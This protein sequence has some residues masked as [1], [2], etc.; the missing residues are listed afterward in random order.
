LLTGVQP[1]KADGDV[2]H[3]EQEISLPACVMKFLTAAA[4]TNPTPRARRAILADDDHH[5]DDTSRIQDHAIAVDA[6]QHLRQDREDDRGDGRPG[7]GA[8]SAED[9][10]MMRISNER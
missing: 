10:V 8:E 4:A 2:A 7:D 9:H 3:V 5:H 1:A 6:P